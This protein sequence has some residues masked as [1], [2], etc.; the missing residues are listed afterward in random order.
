MESLFLWGLCPERMSTIGCLSAHPLASYSQEAKG[1]QYQPSTK[2]RGPLSRACNALGIQNHGIPCPHGN[3]EQAP[4]QTTYLC[5]PSVS[6]AKGQLWSL[7]GVTV[8]GGRA[9]RGALLDCEEVPVSG[10]E[11]GACRQEASQLE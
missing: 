1:R 11:T 8:A 9:V 10:M 4:C 7:L 6:V 3:L 5:T 2:A